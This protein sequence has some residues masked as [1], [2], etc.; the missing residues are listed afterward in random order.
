MVGGT[1]ARLLTFAW[2]ALRER[3]H[4]LGGFHLLLNG[5]VTQLLARLCG[6]RSLYFCGGG[7]TEVL[8]GGV[9]GSSIYELALSV[10]GTL[11]GTHAWLG[12]TQAR[13][14]TDAGTFPGATYRHLFIGTRPRPTT[15]GNAIDE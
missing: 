3:P 15:L 12:S 6:A 1:P 9:N 7:P 10:G 11:R 13:F 5:L 8:D 2:L 14:G 4:V